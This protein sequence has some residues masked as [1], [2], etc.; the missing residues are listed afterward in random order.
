MTKA[1]M[2][3]DPRMEMGSAHTSRI[4]EV[5]YQEDEV[6]GKMKYYFVDLPVSIF[7]D[8]FRPNYENKG[9]G[10][11]TVKRFFTYSRK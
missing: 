5:P 10:L 3:K 7:S 4:R 2:A 11:K 1:K 8:L 6:F 9:E